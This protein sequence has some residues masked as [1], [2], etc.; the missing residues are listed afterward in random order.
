MWLVRLIVRSC[1]Y[2]EVLTVQYNDSTFAILQWRRGH[3]GRPSDGKVRINM[4]SSTCIMS[5]NVLLHEST[6][7]T[8]TLFFLTE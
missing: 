7:Y 2:R 6:P 3:E 4:V 8:R 5:C 1:T